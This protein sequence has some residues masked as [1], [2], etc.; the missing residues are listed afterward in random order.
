M[1]NHK[2]LRK[3]L[4]SFCQYLLASLNRKLRMGLLSFCD[5]LTKNACPYLLHPENG[6]NSSAEANP[7]YINLDMLHNPFT[8]KT[9]IISVVQ[10]INIGFFIL[11]S[12][13]PEWDSTML[14][15]LYFS[16]HPTKSWDCSLF[17]PCSYAPVICTVQICVRPAQILNGLDSSPKKSQVL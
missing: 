13:P 14:H 2:S 8:D 1:L 11:L 7:V 10:L 4:L 9:C 16:T 15:E 3:T 6:Q 12:P 17:L 5:T